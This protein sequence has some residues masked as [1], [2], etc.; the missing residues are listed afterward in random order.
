MEVTRLWVDIYIFMLRHDSI[1]FDKECRKLLANIHFFDVLRSDRSIS[2]H[3]LEAR[4]PFLDRKFVQYYLS[5]NPNLRH[6]ASQNKPEKY[7][8]REAIDMYSPG[9]LLVTYC[10]EL[11]KL[12]VTV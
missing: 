5:I 4:T 2:S 9:L 7:I 11:K 10:G 8:I 3:G 1:A 6:H 12:L